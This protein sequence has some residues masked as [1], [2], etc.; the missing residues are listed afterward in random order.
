M[1]LLLIWFLAYIIPAGVAGGIALLFPRKSIEPRR[2][3]LIMHVALI[4]SILA[5]QY[6]IYVY[7]LSFP[8][9]LSVLSLLALAVGTGLATAF[10]GK[11][12]FWYAISAFI[13]E[14]TMLS[15]A[16]LLLPAFPVYIV[17]LLIVPIFVACHFL[18]LDHW[19]AKLTLIPLWG[20][21]SI[22]LFITT[23]SVYLITAFHTAFGAF[24]FSRSVLGSGMYSRPAKI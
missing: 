7:R 5:S 24:L 12:G 14:L 18:T 16:F 9:H 2:D 4:I 23:H 22:L 13:Q 19:K 17:I 15:I 8:W 1:Q 20:I 11:L 3:V 21:A 10:I 6:V